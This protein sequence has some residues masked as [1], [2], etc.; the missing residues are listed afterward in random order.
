MVASRVQYSAGGGLKFLVPPFQRNALNFAASLP[1]EDLRVEAARCGAC[2]AIK[3]S[4]FPIEEDYFDDDL[5]DDGEPEQEVGRTARE[6]I[7]A[8]NEGSPPAV[9]TSPANSW[10]GRKALEATAV[11]EYPFT[12]A[13]E[14]TVEELSA[15]LAYFQESQQIAAR[16]TAADAM[17]PFKAPVNGYSAAQTHA[18]NEQMK[19]CRGLHTV[20]EGK[21]I[22]PATRLVLREQLHQLAT[23][24]A[25]QW[26]T[27]E[28]GHVAGAAFTL[29]VHN[30][31][32]QSF[33]ALFAPQLEA[34]QEAGK[35]D[36]ALREARRQAA[37]TW[38]SWYAAPAKGGWAPPVGA[39][40]GHSPGRAEARA[41]GRA[42]KA[43][44]AGPPVPATT[45]TP[46]YCYTC[47]QQGH[48]SNACPN[49]APQA[50]PVAPSWANWTSSA[51]SVPVQ[52]APAPGLA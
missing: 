45:L 31:T 12:H 20:A 4:G 37:I 44:K 24:A 10:E 29:A 47:Y 28:L 34:A 49:S 7:A 9:F 52:A 32:D 50:A 19:V 21:N 35:A 14:G 48:K 26:V 2:R 5:D 46:V 51:P 11:M 43:G 42:A 17:F 3:T 8:M 27:T 6:V 36:E 40:T 22:D 1:V 39:F 41:K 18:Y 33:M 30:T 16:Q 23:T 13:G 15:R 25:T 38:G